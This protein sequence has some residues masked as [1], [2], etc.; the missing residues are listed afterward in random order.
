VADQQVSTAMDDI[1]VF[2]PDISDPDK[3]YGRSSCD[4]YDHDLK[5]R[6]AAIPYRYESSSQVDQIH[7]LRR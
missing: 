4:R 3:H 6:S 2:R 1:K 5:N 7:L